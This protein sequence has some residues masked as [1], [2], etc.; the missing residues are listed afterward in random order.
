VD[1]SGW[2]ALGTGAAGLL[3]SFVVLVYG[4]RSFREAQR[5]N[6]FAAAVQFLGDYR[7][8]GPARFDLFATLASQALDPELGLA[9]FDDPGRR[10]DVVRLAHYLDTL[11]LLVARGIMDQDTAAA[12]LGSSAVAVWEALAPFVVAE[13]TIRGDPY[14]WAH[15]EHFAATVVAKDR[16]VVLKDL[17]RYPLPAPATAAAWAPQ[18]PSE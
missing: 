14:V 15:F 13:R 4:V 8:L 6:A 1:A 2:L 12:Y 18:R 3:L 5:A 17:R 10:S 9:A 16:A 7:E 11:G